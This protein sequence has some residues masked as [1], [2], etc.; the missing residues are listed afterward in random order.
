MRRILLDRAVNVR[1]LGG[2]PTANG[3]MTP[4]GRFWRADNMHGLSEAD[5]EKLYDLGIRTIVDLR[6]P[7]EVNAQPNCFLNYRD[8]QVVSCS[9]LGESTDSF[10]GF[11]CSLG[12]RYTVMIERDGPRYVELFDALAEGAARGGVLFHCTAGKDRTGVT[13]ALLLGLAGVPDVDIVAD[14]A[15]TDTYL[16][17]KIAMFLSHAPADVDP[18]LFRAQPENMQTFVDFL[19]ERYGTA[20]DYLRGIGVPEDVLAQIWG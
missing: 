11:L 15:L 4:F 9:L 16:Q 3:G 7:G 6:T 2:Y 20:E 10:T 5:M 1:D 8:V 12:E 13:A 14:Y 19:R 18:N 17:P